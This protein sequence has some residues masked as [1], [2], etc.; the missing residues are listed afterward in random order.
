MVFNGGTIWRLLHFLD[1]EFN[2]LEPLKLLANLTDKYDFNDFYYYNLLKNKNITVV[3]DDG[4]FKFKDIEIVTYRYE[5][6]NLNK[7]I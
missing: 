4:D 2:A 3:T 5:L 6:I 7:R 1:D